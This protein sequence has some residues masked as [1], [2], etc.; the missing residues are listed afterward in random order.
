MWA[1][2]TFYVCFM[3]FIFLPP[4][5]LSACGVHTQINQVV[6]LMSHSFLKMASCRQGKLVTDSHHRVELYSLDFFF[7]KVHLLFLL[8]H[9]KFWV[10][11]CTRIGKHLAT[12]NRNK[13]HLFISCP[14]PILSLNF[15]TSVDDLCH[16]E[17]SGTSFL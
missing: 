14:I 3:L 5:R 13:L 4:L 9:S 7:Y 17:I 16:S 11:G 8:P 1:T 15:F 10:C 12:E 6:S 2:E